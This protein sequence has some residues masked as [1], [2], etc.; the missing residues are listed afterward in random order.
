VAIAVSV[1]IHNVLDQQLRVFG[2]I[3]IAEHTEQRLVD[4]AIVFEHMLLER[5]AI[6]KRVLLF[7]RGDLGR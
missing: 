1:R 4:V 2:A 3:L 7:Q 6:R 5:T